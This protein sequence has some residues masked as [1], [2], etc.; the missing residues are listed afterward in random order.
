ML[1][2]NHLWRLRA[3]A[4]VICLLTVYASTPQTATNTDLT[5]NLSNYKTYGFVPQLG[6]NRGGNTANIDVVDA[7]KRK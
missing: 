2:Q 1:S 4:V 3:L 6:T 7:S 5:A